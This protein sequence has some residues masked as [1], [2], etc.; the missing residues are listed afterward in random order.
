MSKPAEVTQRKAKKIHYCADCGKPILPGSEYIC[1][2]GR[3]NGGHFYRKEHIH[4]DA[5]INAYCGAMG[6]EVYYERLD[7]VVA[8]IRDEVCAKCADRESCGAG[9]QDTFSCSVVLRRVL[10]PTVL[11]AALQSVRENETF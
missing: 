6:C 11:Y 10:A 9:G 8:W 7:G 3:Q 2:H 5:V 4:C 1:V